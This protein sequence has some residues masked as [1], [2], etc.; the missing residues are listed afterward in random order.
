MIIISYAEQYVLG[1]SS[2]HSQESS[3]YTK[4]DAPNR[5]P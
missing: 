4:F 5:D 2:L 1:F 3:V